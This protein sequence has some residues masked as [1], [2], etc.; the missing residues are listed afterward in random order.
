MIP[1]PVLP[2]NGFGSSIFDLEIDMSRLAVG[3]R[4]NHFIPLPNSYAQIPAA[5]KMALQFAID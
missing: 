4:N 2:K 1:K 5:N 3:M